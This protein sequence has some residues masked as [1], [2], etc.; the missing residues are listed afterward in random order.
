MTRYSGKGWHFQHV[1]HSNA[2]KYGKAGGTY[3]QIVWK[4]PS[5]QPYGVTRMV[6]RDNEY[7][8]EI[9]IDYLQ[10]VFLPK[11][12]KIIEVNEYK[13]PRKMSIFKK[14]GLTEGWQRIAH[15]DFPIKNK[16]DEKKL[17]RYVSQIQKKVK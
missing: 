1:R 6:G 16:R 4:K 5:L 17:E 7:E 2:R 11:G 14:M 8:Y 9:E 12:E 15:E 13:R 10:D 3:S